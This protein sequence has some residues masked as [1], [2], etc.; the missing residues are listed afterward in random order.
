MDQRASTYVAMRVFT[1]AF[2]KPENARRGLEAA[3]RRGGLLRS[4]CVGVGGL[5]G[6]F[7]PKVAKK[8]Q[9]VSIRHLETD[10]L[11]QLY[12]TLPPTWRP[13]FQHFSGWRRSARYVE[14]EQP[15]VRELTT[16][17]W[18]IDGITRACGF[19]SLRLAWWFPGGLLKYFP[20]GVPHPGPM[21]AFGYDDAYY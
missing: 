6:P 15:R 7:A 19:I 20:A 9:V 8:L 18:W 2:T 10:E 4:P 14:E 11:S 21:N 1:E 17:E 3:A 12:P 5:A 16:E 13:F